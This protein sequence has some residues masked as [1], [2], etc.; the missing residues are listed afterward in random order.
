MAGRGR[1][2]GGGI[3]QMN[4]NMQDLQRQFVAL[5]AMI[6]QRG[7]QGGDDTDE[8]EV[9]KEE[10]TQAPPLAFEERMLRALEGKNDGI[11]VDVSEY[12]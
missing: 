12:G 9:C 6:T 4:R 2:R 1:G 10:E 8:E 7:N 3:A 11:R 5:V